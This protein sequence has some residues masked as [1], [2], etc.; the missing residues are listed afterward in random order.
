VSGTDL[1]LPN[2]ETMPIRDHRSSRTLEVRDPRGATQTVGWR[3]PVMPQVEAW[4]AEQAFR[5]GYL[6][7]V[8]AYRCIQLRSDAVAKIPLVAGRKLGDYTTLRDDAPIIKLLG[9]PPGGPAPRL[10]ARKLIRWTIAQELV[11]GRRAWEIETD[12]KRPDGRPIAFW[13]LSSAHLR[14]VPSKGGNEWFRVFHYGNHHDPVKLPPELVFYGWDPSGTDFRQAESALQAARY[15]LSLVT[16]CDQYGLGFLRNNAVP[17]AIITTTKFPDEA[18]KRKFMANWES[19][20][21]GPSNAGRVALNELDDDGDGAVGDSIDVKVLGLSAKDARLVETRKEAMHEI[22]IA[23]GTPWSKLDASG[24]TFD[25]ADAEDAT[26]HNETILSDLLDLQDDINMQLSPRLGDEVVWFDLRN[27]PAFQRRHVPISQPVGAPLLVQAQLWTIDEARADYGQDPLPDGAGARLMTAEEIQALRGAAGGGDGGS[28][29]RAALAAIETRLDGLTQPPA[30]VV[31][32][33]GSAE[34]RQEPGPEQR[35]VDPEAVETRRASIWRAT[36]AVATSIEGRWERAFRRLFA[37]QLDATIA[38]LTGKRGRQALGYAANG[39][40]SDPIEDLSLLD[41]AALFSLEFWRSETVAVAEDLYAMAAGAG[42]DRVAM[43]FGVSFDVEA[44]WVTEYI[45]SRANQLAGQVTQTT[46]DAITDQLTQGVLEGESIDDLAARIRSVF[47][48]ADTARSVTIARTE[49]ISAFNGAAV[50][51]AS[52]LP[53]DVV[54]AQEWIATRDGRTRDAHAA[55]DGQV[56]LIGSPFDVAGTAAAYP[57]DPALPASQTVNCRCAVA[58]LTPDEYAE[59]GRSAAVGVE[60]RVAK[61]LMALVPS[62]AEFDLLGF[63]R[64]LEESAA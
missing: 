59:L 26:W 11:T 39:T 35:I 20:H 19:E 33:A 31:T 29:V 41:I 60:Q 13:P 48:N 47:A 54:I 27:V 36:D 9:P 4:N 1:V 17:A 45:T 52:S 53:S 28:A 37:R 32:T 25:N 44:P 61:S 51:G 55:V 56:Q 21:M 63:R 23:L 14:A 58:F 50:A 34:Q 16:L 6:A 40:R 38:R 5:L 24:R 15:D 12:T 43:T 8:I 30:P 62:G 64:A 18:S 2:G 46:Y 22:A 42:L 57:G 10:S 49:V 7:N 3:S